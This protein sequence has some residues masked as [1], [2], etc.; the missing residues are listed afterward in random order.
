MSIATDDEDIGDYY[1]AKR[2]QSKAKRASNREQSTQMLVDAK[3]RFESKN[4][5]AHLIINGGKTTIDFW[6]G[7]GKWLVR[8]DKRWNRGIAKL[9]GLIAALE[10]M[11]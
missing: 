5:G 10:S 8:G 1:R 11:K 9:L 7:T 6:P 4:D 3:V 2:E